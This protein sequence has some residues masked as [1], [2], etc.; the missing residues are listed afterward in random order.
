MNVIGFQDIGYL[1]NV[2]IVDDEFRASR[3]TM[4]ACLVSVSTLAFLDITYFY[5]TS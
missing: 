5:L 1:L 4:A 2:A 3:I